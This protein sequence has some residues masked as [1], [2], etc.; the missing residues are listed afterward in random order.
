MSDAY[1]LMAA[2]FA[3]ELLAVGLIHSRELLGVHELGTAFRLL[4]LAWVVA[5]PVATLAGAVYEGMATLPFFSKEMRAA[6]AAVALGF[7]SAALVLEMVASRLG[8]GPSPSNRWAFGV[9][10]LLAAGAVSLALPRSAGRKL[11]GPIGALVLFT[12]SA[13]IAPRTTDRLALSDNVRRVYGDGAVLLGRVV[14]LSGVFSPPPSFD[15][16]RPAVTDAPLGFDLTGTD[17][18]L[19][20]L[21]RAR[22][23]HLGVYGYER[24]TSPNIDRIAKTGIVFDEAYVPS[25]DATFAVASLMTGKYM[26]PLTLEGF[27]ADSDTFAESLGRYGF[28]TDIG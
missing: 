25:P 16:T 23:D 11:H 5:A 8:A 17:I 28:K 12:L 24:A 10:A 4:P 15:A 21:H 13:A 14:E 22:R 7:A 2:F 19:V 27:G 26:R 3:I 20:T 1:L 6:R 9:L 18:L